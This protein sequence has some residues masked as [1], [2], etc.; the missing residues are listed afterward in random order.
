MTS[1]DARTA[2]IEQ[3]KQLILAMPMAQTL[4]LRFVRVVPGEVELEVPVSN[5]FFVFG[6]ASFRPPPCL[7]R[8]TSLRWRQRP[9]CCRPAGSMR[10]SMPS[11]NAP[12]RPTGT[13]CARGWVV[14]TAS[15]LTI[16]A[17]DVFAVNGDKDTLCSTLLGTACKLA[18]AKRLMV[19][20][21]SEKSIKMG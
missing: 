18:P 15:L 3:L 20:D 14:H 5:E 13:A 11:S 6:R 12:R 10:W 17:A 1:T 19:A 4:G 9:R 16:C 7:P 21:F 8:P 2:H